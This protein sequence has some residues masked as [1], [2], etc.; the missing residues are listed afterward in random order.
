MRRI[1]DWNVMTPLTL[2]VLESMVPLGGGGGGAT[3]AA[4]VK[5]PKIS[6]NGTLT[7]G[8]HCT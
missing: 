1:I 5:T 2:L 6:A 8:I 7:V 4:P 3:V